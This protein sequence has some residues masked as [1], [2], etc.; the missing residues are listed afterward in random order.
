[1]V[2]PAV[3]D[4]VARALAK[5]PARRYPRGADLAEE[6]A[7]AL[8]EPR[9]PARDAAA[10]D[11]APAPWTEA[12]AIA[13]STR[14]TALDLER[15]AAPAVL[16]PVDGA[17]AVVVVP[18]GPPRSRALAIARRIAAGLAAVLELDGP[19]RVTVAEVRAGR[20]LRLRRPERVLALL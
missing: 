14:D 17:R 7:A 15:A 11:A 18:P 8:A 16:A 3:D 2:P 6:L 1:D 5:D 4:V 9:R 19:P 20:R 13:L 12:A 10:P